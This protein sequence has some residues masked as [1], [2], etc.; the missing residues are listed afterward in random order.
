MDPMAFSSLPAEHV[1]A[2]LLVVGIVVTSCFFML[3]KDTCKMPPMAEAGYFETISTF[4]IGKNVPKFVLKNMRE[5]GNVFRL[6]MPEMVPWVVVSDSA[7]ARQIL[8]E[9]DEKPY[10]YKRFEGF[11]ANVTTLFSKRTHGDNW[12]A[13]RKALAPSFS[14]MNI[15]TTLPKMYEK[16]EELKNMFLAYEKDGS[17]FEISTITTRLTM[18]FICA[19]ISMYFLFLIAF[20]FVSYYFEFAFAPFYFYTL[21]D[22]AL[23]ITHRYSDPDLPRLSLPLPLLSLILPPLSLPQRC[24]VLTIRRYNQRTPQAVF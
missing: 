12:G 24:S 4:M 21:C 19:G 5:S 20:V 11:T 7:L 14:M 16:I 17:T 22:T 9:E 18:D 1:P 8:M 3:R 10:L 6:N 2:V 15:C 23:Y 13:S